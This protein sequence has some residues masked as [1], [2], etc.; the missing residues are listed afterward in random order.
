MKLLLKII[1]I[2]VIVRW[3]DNLRIENNLTYFELF[4]ISPKVLEQSRPKSS[5]KPQLKKTYQTKNKKSKFS[6]D[7]VTIIPLG[8]VDYSNLTDAVKII[9]NFYGYNCIIGKKE[10]ITND[11][12]I[13]NTDKILD[14][15]YCIKKFYN[16]NKTIYIV[17]KKLW[18]KGDYLRGYAL[19]GGGTVLVRGNSSFLEETIIHELGHTLGLGHCDDL[20]C[21]MAIENDA[22]DSGTFCN[23]CKRKLGV[24]E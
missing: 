14:A 1:A 17:D 7:N 20:T 5:Y 10:E 22:Y 3:V 18:A 8:N 12:Y 6:P 9:K 19:R 24:Y 4:S 23:N 15:D 21:I 13:K 11:M 16:M 2:L